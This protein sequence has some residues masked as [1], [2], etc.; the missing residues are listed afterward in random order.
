[1]IV[2]RA[3]HLGVVVVVD[4]AEG[5]LTPSAK[6]ATAARAIAPKAAKPTTLDRAI[7]A[8]K[9]P[10]TPAAVE[11]ALTPAPAGGIWAVAI[12]EVVRAKAARVNAI[13][14]MMISWLQKYVSNS[15][16]IFLFVN[17]LN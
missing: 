2:S 3:D 13:F 1:M 6:S 9:A 8:P 15:M 10:A 12:C 5:T 14:C 16:Q 11:A 4:V 17:K 7:G